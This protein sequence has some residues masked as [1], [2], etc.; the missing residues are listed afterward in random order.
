MLSTQWLTKSQANRDPLPFAQC[1]T[2]GM[3][4]ISPFQR[5]DGM[6]AFSAT[7]QASVQSSDETHMVP[8]G[9]SANWTA[10][11]AQRSFWYC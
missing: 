4:S 5:E 1:P 11:V 9:V 8:T 10:A 3:M 6:I 7:I 2:T